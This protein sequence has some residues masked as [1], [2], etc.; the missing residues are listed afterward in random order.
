VEL[1]G[2]RCCG[3]GGLFNLSHP[4]LSQKIL[5]HPLT[6]LDQSGADVITT[7]CMACLMQ[8]K[9]GVQSSGRKVRV[10]HWTELM[11]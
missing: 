4:D 11:V 1:E 3:H 10:K 8:F 2:H 7:S 6:D 5:D 9:S